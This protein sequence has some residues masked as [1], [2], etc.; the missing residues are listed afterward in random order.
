MSDLNAVFEFINLI[1]HKLKSG[2]AACGNEIEK[3]IRLIKLY[4]ENENNF[5]YINKNKILFR[6][7]KYTEPDAETRYNNPVGIFAGYD[8]AGSFVN[9]NIHQNTGSR[10]NSVGTP[11]LYTAL[12][13]I[14]CIYEVRAKK[15]DYIS[16]ARIKVEQPLK[17]LCFNKR[18]WFVDQKEP[19]LSEENNAVLCSYL[20]YEFSR[21]VDNSNDYALCQYVSEIVK[22]LGYDGMS[23]FSA[24]PSV[25][26]LKDEAKTNIV[27]FN[28]DKCKPISSSL[29][30]ITN[31]NI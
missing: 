26:S 3:L 23:Y 31:E 16:V 12:S 30:K 10:C 22:S 29:R 24:L 21:K 19:I 17:I 14:C 20:A 27:I 9:T 25:E 28:Y 8:A 4:A 6:A 5:H 1:K 2:E 11:Y 13:E 15:G 7:R 18:F